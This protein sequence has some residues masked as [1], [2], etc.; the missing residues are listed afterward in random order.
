MTAEITAAEAD[1]ANRFPHEPFATR[2][3]LAGHPLFS[4]PALA[5]LAKTLPRD[6]VEYNAGDLEPGVKPEDVPTLDMSAEEVVR[7]IEQCNAWMVLKR[8]E[9]EPAYRALLEEVLTGVAQKLGHRSLEEAG[10]YD[11]QGFVF[12][13]SAN[14]TTPFHVDPEENFFVQIHGPK[15]FHIFDNRDRSFL[16]D[17]EL[18]MS[19]SKHRNKRYDPSYEAKA[20]VFSLQPGDG[21]FVPHLWPHWVRTGDSY[22]VSMAI[23]WKSPR[24]ERLNTLLRANGLLR[25]YGFPQPAPGVNPVMD[26]VKIAAY[27][28][29][30]TAVE[31]LRRTEGMR[32]FLRGLVFGRQANYYYREK[33][34]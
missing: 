12:V 29:L 4:L 33:K 28:A 30:R 22:S 3:N 2:H 1:L 20:Q 34:A 23:T 13:A 26:G 21:L 8:V 7:R 16:T 31:P 15:F 32:R 14:A 6:R 24:A 10:F 18:E 9:V 11:I 17:E 25:K 27:R 5:R 19:P